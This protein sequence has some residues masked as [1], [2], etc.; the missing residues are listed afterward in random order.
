MSRTTQV[1]SDSIKL[2][3]LRGYHPLRPLFPKRCAKVL[4]KYCRRSYNPSD[5][6]TSLV[7]AGAR[8]LA[9]TCAITIVFSSSGYLDVS[10]PRVCPALCAVPSLGWWVA[11][12]GNP[13]LNGYLPLGMAYRS[14]SRPSSPPRAKAS[15]MCPFLLS[16]IVWSFSPVYAIELGSIWVVVYIKRACFASAFELLATCVAALV[17]DMS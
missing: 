3:R 10:V 9:T 7:W 1:P 17:L 13:C 14:L 12:F 8:S 5:A 16:F 4:L 2:F 11:P 6:V 15:F